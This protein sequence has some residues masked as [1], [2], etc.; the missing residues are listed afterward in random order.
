MDYGI[1]SAILSPI[2][3]SVATI[4]KSGATKALSPLAVASFGTIIG[5][6][7]IMIFLI[8]RKKRPTIKKIK[9]NKKDFFKL[10]L[11]RGILGEIFIVFGLSMTAAIKAIFFTK[12]EAYFVLFLSWFLK[13]EKIKPIHIVLVSAN[14]VG[15]ILL[16]TAGDFSMLG[17]SQIGD[18][19]IIIAMAFFACSYFY[20]QRLSK[21]IGALTTS[22]VSQLTGGLFLLP[23]VLFLIPQTE[24][25][26]LTGW[27]YLLSF[28]LLFNVVGLSLW[29]FSLKT[30]KP[31]IVSA[32]RAIGPLAGAPL[33]FLMFGDVLNL[34]QIVGA[35]IIL[36]SSSAIVYEHR[37]KPL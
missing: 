10:I 34:V 28:V 7:L 30:V 19:F 35:A 14:I 17:T 23:F 31:W 37:R 6:T 27:Y 5:G 24:I 16:S 4:F 2:L 21:K 22:S 32:L 29:Y 1:L 8:F 36:V 15:V 20:S 12:I 11:F 18:L 26:S 33:A 3:S 25:V 13:K 9:E